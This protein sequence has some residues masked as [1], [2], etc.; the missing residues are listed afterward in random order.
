MSLLIHPL[1]MDPPFTEYSSLIDGNMT[2]KDSNS[3]D[4]VVRPLQSTG[5]DGAF[6]V[7]VPPEAL[8]RLNLKVGELC[9]ISTAAGDAFGYGITWRATDKMGNSPKARPAKMTDMLRNAYGI[10]E[11]SHVTLEKVNA[12][13]IHAE[14]VTLMDVTPTEY[15][16]GH[17]A[18]VEDDKWWGRCIYAL[19][20]PQP[21]L[22]LVNPS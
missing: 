15:M 17:G 9:T 7:H 4:F 12:E 2:E 14:K 22:G 18:E 10:K 6:R 11:G 21:I 16:D 8:E 19:R 1:R 5:L 3:R 20:K 13:V